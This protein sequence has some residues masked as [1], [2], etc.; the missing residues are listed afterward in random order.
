MANRIISFLCVLTFVSIGC[1]AVELEAGNS[2]AIQSLKVATGKL[3]FNDTALSEPAGQS[4]NSCHL[5]DNFYADPGKIVSPGASP[6]LFGNRNAP[7]ISYVKFTPS[8]YWDNDEE[9]WVGGFFLDGRANTLQDQAKE[10][11]VNT[12]EM[13]NPD[14]ATLI[15]KV[16]QADYA[17]ALEQLYGKDIWSD[18]NKALKAVTD[19]IA[20]Y[21]SGPE[22]ATFTSKYD[23]YLQGK[24]DLTELENKGLQLFE[25]EDKGNCAACHPSQMQDNGGLP[26]FTDYTYDNLGLAR[27]DKLPFYKTPSKY[28]AEGASYI[29]YGLA[30]NPLINN[31]PDEKGKFKVSTL[32]NISNTAPYMHNGI[33]ESLKEVVDFYNSRDVNEKW[34]KP[35]LQYNLNEDELG[36][37]NLTDEEVKA[38]VAFMETLSDGFVIDH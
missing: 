15:A 24:V 17:P 14:V 16:K 4:C 8:I 10:P 1:S 31:G 35:E 28:N 2:E 22:F 33:F 38:I 6:E 37:L 21:E 19:T 23:Y 25:A 9:H 32:R 30:E 34:G 26:L 7:S 29:D 36:D 18:N 13:G 27:P 5:S 12:L 11:F 3:I 20:A